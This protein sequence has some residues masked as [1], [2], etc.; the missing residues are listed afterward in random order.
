[1]PKSGTKKMPF[2]RNF[3]PEFEKA[4]VKSEVSTLEFLKNESLTY[5]VNLV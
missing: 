3:G 4:V 5:T 2:L 1:M